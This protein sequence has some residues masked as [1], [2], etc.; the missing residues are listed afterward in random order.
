V[1]VIGGYIQDC[2]ISHNEIYDVSYSAIS[3]GWGWGRSDVSVGPKR[4]TPWKEPSVCMRN[5]ILY[6]HI[7]RC[8][9][10]LCD[11]G[12]I[13]TIGCMTGTSIIGNYIHESAGFHGDG[14]DGVVICGYQ[15]EE[16]YDPKREPFMKLTGVP[17][18][19]YQDEGSR[20]I[21]IS[22]NIL[23]DVPLP[24]FYHNQIDKGYTMVEYKDNYINKRPGDEGFPVELAACAGVEPEYKF[25]L[26]A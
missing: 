14:Y 8:M 22:N 5:R 3:L 24:F 17:G 19:I 12:G 15:T 1:A 18:G 4:P 26:D 9:M 25:L 16:F 2:S 10:T 11:G 20:G 6:N 7:Y 13:Y 23:H 21:E